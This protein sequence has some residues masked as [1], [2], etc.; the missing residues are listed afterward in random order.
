[1]FNLNVKGQKVLIDDCMKPLF[2]DH[3]W[4]IDAGGVFT[5]FGGGTKTYLHDLVLVTAP[6]NEVIHRNGNKLNN[7]AENLSVRAI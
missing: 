2:D 6:G 1:M 7:L 5:Y 4:D 3:E